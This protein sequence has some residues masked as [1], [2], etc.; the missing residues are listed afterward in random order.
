MPPPPGMELGPE[1]PPPPRRLPE[2]YAFRTRFLTNVATM[3]GLGFTAVGAI[4]ALAM[5]AAP[6][7]ALTFPGFLLV[8]GIS[9]LKH[10]LGSANRVLDAFRNGRAVKGHISSVSLDTSVKI[11]GRSPWNIVYTFEADGHPYEGKVS[12]META[13]SNRFRGSPPVWV[14]AVDGRPERNT[15]YPPVK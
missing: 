7:W 15:L 6:W 11:N 2:G 5:V 4:M 10:G 12:T 8:G 9:L 13:T 14:L 3:I 1:P